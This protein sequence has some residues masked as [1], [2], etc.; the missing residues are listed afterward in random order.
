MNSCAVPQ[1][2]PRNWFKN[3]IYQSYGEKKHKFMKFSPSL[4]LMVQSY[5]EDD[6]Q[7]VFSESILK[8]SAAIIMNPLP[9]EKI[10]N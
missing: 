2:E 6:F 10:R 3:T 1:H 8:F 9:Y 7:Y 4:N 5:D